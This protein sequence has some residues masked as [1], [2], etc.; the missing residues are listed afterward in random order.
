MKNQQILAVA[1]TVVASMATVQAQSV[2]TAWNFTATQAA[3]LSSVPATTGS[4]TI[5]LIGFG[6]G[7]NTPNGDVAL[8]AGTANS[9]FSEYLLRARNS[10]NAWSLT[11]P[12]YSQGI[13]LDAST[14]GQQ[15]IGF[16]F[17]WYSTTQGIR[18]LA[19]EYNLDTGNSSGWTVIGG[20]TSASTYLATPNDYYGA[21]SSSPTISIDL[22]SIT[23]ANN[24]PTF[25]IRLVSAF[26][27]T[28]NTASYASAT[29]SSGKTVAYNGTS[30][31]WR[32]GNLD[33]TGTPTAAPE[34]APMAL[35]GLGLTTLF[36][37]RRYRKA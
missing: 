3:P 35:V 37:F 25:G 17:D 5:N 15:N 16:T 8:T 12:Q 31:N 11:A 26:D 29:L 6:F 34:P 14:A 1:A 20:T 33:L 23:G 2:F 28:G 32:F 10:A 24:D 18:D 13:E 7:G 9:T 19:V 22:S 27:S 21:A 36:A 4:G 30:G